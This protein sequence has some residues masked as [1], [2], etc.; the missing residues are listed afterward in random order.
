MKFFL[1]C[2]RCLAGHKNL[3]N[4]FF[5]IYVFPTPGR[6]VG[7]RMETRGPEF[8]CV[9]DVMFDQLFTKM[10]NYLIYDIIRGTKFVIYIPFLF[11]NC[12][13]IAYIL[14]VCD[15]VLKGLS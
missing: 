9:F 10:T 3:K 7:E 15:T 14:I 2:S 5:L 8:S 1:D 12:S 6:M 11:C 13:M 4:L